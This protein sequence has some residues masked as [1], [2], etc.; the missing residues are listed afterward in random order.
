MVMLGDSLQEAGPWNCSMSWS[1]T[2]AIFLK[3]DI[4]TCAPIVCTKKCPDDRPST[5]AMVLMLGS[6]IALPLPKEPGFFNGRHPFQEHN[7]FGHLLLSPNEV[8]MTLL[9]FR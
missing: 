9:S 5:S 2:H 3:T 8:T 6:D 1:R 7:S 4:Y